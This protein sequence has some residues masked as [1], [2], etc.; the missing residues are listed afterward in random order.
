MN[1][2]QMLFL[3][4]RIEEQVATLY[5][6]RHH[7]CPA[8]SKGET[9]DIFLGDFVFVENDKN[10][11]P[12]VKAKENHLFQNNDGDFVLRTGDA[13]GQKLSELPVTALVKITE[14]LDLLKTQNNINH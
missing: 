1:D 9:W 2:T 7:R 6:K 3:S 14:L 12:V 5:R 11:N 10:G 8:F 4:A 13:P